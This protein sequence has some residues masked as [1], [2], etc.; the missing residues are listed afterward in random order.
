METRTRQEEKFAHATSAESVAQRRQAQMEHWRAGG[1]VASSLLLCFLM[2]IG[3]LLLCMMLIG[4][5]AT[6]RSF[7]MLDGVY[8]LG[9]WF[10]GRRHLGLSQGVEMADQTLVKQ[11]A[12][13][14]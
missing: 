13:A 11:V 10:L 12:S 3:G 14:S 1:V 5:Q 6:C 7:V 8:L 2:S 4:L 9:I